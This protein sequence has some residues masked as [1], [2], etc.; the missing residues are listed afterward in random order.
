MRKIQII[1]NGDF[2]INIFNFSTNTQL[3][4]NVF[5]S[6]NDWGMLDID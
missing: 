6:E 3:T 5:K 1:G 4:V 2:N